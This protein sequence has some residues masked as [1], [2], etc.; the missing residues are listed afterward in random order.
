MKGG[1]NMEFVCYLIFGVITPAIVTQMMILRN[2]WRMID[3]EMTEDFNK[4][5]QGGEKNG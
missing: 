3:R 2:R 4:W 1:D 5:L